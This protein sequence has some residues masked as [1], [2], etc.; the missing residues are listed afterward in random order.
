MLRSGREAGFSAYEYA[1]RTWNIALDIDFTT[2]RSTHSR[3]LDL[4]PKNRKT[5]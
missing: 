2:S 1:W 3:I 4:S 5:I